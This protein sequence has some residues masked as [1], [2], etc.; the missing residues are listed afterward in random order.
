MKTI[1]LQVLE[2]ELCRMQHLCFETPLMHAVP[3][4]ERRRRAVSSASLRGYVYT[5]QSVAPFAWPLFE[6]FE[7]AQAE[8]LETLE[9][10]IGLLD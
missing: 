1:V 3:K 7:S 5:F 10:L 6:Y 9:S 2:D 8:R 4:P